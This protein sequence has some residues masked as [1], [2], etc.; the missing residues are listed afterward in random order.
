VPLS[1][2]IEVDQTRLG[3]TE[4]VLAGHGKPLI[5][6]RIGWQAISRSELPRTSRRPVSEVLDQT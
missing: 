2:A 1:Q 6:V 4:Q 5:L 3:L